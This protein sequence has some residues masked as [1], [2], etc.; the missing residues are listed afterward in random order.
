MAQS[1][2]ASLSPGSFTVTAIHN[3]LV[4]EMDSGRWTT[5]TGQCARL[6]TSVAVDPKNALAMR[7]TPSEPTHTRLASRDSSINASPARP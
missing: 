1:I 4:S 6:A 2:A 7:P 5:A 3:C